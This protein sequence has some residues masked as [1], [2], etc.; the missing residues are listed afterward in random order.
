M[1]FLKWDYENNSLN[2]TIWAI[3][4]A[5][6]QRIDAFE[7]E[8]TLENPLD[9]K[10][11]KPG[12]SKGNQPWIFTGRTDTEA[13]APVLWPPDVKSQ[14]TGK[15][16]DAGKDWG[17]EK[18]ATEGWDGWMASTT[19]WTWVWA[20]SGRWERTKSLACCAVHALA[21]S[22]TRLSDWTTSHNNNKRFHLK[23][24]WAHLL[25]KGAIDK[26]IT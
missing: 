17:Q 12:N 10:E 4:T 13:E 2:E 9:G 15:D 22:Q 14:L 24:F 3:I 26:S 19:Q 20:N 18:R 21:K 25:K 1:W 7:L 6:H 8:K 16:P 23:F 11:I 5:E